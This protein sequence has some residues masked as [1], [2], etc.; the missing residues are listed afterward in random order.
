MPTWKSIG[1]LPVCAL[2]LW[3]CGEVGLPLPFVDNSKEPTSFSL[4]AKV[5]DFKEGNAVDNTG[6]HPNFNQT[7]W[8]C[9]A[10]TMG[11]TVEPVIAFDGIRD[12]SF[13]G[14]DRRPI[15]NASMPSELARCFEPRDRFPDWYDDRDASV[16]RT[17]LIDMAFERGEDGVYRYRNEKFF[18]IDNGAPF[19]KARAGIPDPFGHLQSGSKD[20]VDLAQHN[21]GFTVEFHGSFKYE[22]GKDQEISVKGDD[23]V[24]IFINDRIALDLGGMHPAQSGTIDL[25]ALG[26]TSGQTYFIDFFFAERSVASSKLHIETNVRF[27]EMK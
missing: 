11:P 16:N 15:L 20:E 4:K 7:R 26:L 8:V 18:P 24:W 9:E 14:D 3:G 22:A 5:R 21:Y 17:Y 19:A 25:D 10:P 6:T 27:G 12:E 23:D 2:F 13:P 1:K